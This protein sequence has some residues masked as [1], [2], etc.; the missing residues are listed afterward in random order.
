MDLNH[1]HYLLFVS[2]VTTKIEFKCNE[3]VLSQESG[4]RICVQYKGVH[5]PQLSRQ[6]L[7]QANKKLNFYD[8]P[9]NMEIED[10]EST[11]SIDSVDGHEWKVLCPQIN[12]PHNVC[13]YDIVITGGDGCYDPQMVIGGCALKLL[14]LSHN[15]KDSL[16]STNFLDFTIDTPL[17]MPRS[18]YHDCTISIPRGE[19]FT[20]SYKTRHMTEQEINAA[21]KL[22]PGDPRSMY[23]RKTRVNVE[24]INYILS[25]WCGMMEQIIGSP[26]IRRRQSVPTEEGQTQAPS[27]HSIVLCN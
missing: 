24:H 22:T 10:M 9:Q 21:G 11:C 7:T 25:Y 13:I 27:H 18:P 1:A 6:Y 17:Y 2:L 20:M 16:F 12:L 5:L 4:V 8:V 19:S 23:G 26:E 3:A 15:K 14:S